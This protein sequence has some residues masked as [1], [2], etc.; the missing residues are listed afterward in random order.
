MVTSKFYYQLPLDWFRVSVLSYFIKIC[1]ES[2]RS[3]TKTNILVGLNTS[4]V[5]KQLKNAPQ[6]MPGAFSVLCKPAKS[7]YYYYYC[8]WLFGIQ[9]LRGMAC[10]WI[11]C[12]FHFHLSLSHNLNTRLANRIFFLVELLFFWLDISIK[13]H[14]PQKCS[15]N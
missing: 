7:Y 6:K 5:Y 4:L 14:W 8:S 12:S 9:S 3:S 2:T 10:H 13:T 1:H 15:I 11:I